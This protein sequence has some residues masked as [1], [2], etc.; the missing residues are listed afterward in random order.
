MTLQQTFTPYEAGTLC[1]SALSAG[2]SLAAHLAN[3][4]TAMRA[5]HATTPPAA[6]LPTQPRPAAPVAEERTRL[7]RP[8]M[9]I[10][11]G[12]VDPEDESLYI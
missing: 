5:T 3:K 12:D 10:P 6:V 2:L 4:I 11:A 7:I 8:G 1:A 9:T